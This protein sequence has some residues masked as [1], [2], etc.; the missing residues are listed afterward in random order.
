MDRPL[1]Q[2]SHEGLRRRRRSLPTPLPHTLRRLAGCNSVALATECIGLKTAVWRLGRRRLVR[3]VLEAATSA[4][5]NG[6]AGRACLLRCRSAID[7][8][9]WSEDRAHVRVRAPSTVWAPARDG[10][11]PDE[12]RQVLVQ[13]T[14]LAS[15]HTAAAAPAA[16]VMD[17]VEGHNSL[18]GTEKRRTARTR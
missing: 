3:S 5:G 6:I 16:A 18:V 12:Y 11:V 15:I 4:I 2:S 8:R 7:R 10:K 17:S 1:Q 14:G 9:G 13:F